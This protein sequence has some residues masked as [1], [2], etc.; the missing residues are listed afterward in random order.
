VV[1]DADAN[2]QYDWNFGAVRRTESAAL[3]DAMGIRKTPA[4]LLISPS[5]EIARR[6]DG[7]ASPAE[8][9]LA[10]KHFLGPTG[11]NPGLD[12]R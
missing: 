9:G 1:A 11:G 3:G 2:L 8:L 7:F 4:L 12:L 5:G 6:W 10:L